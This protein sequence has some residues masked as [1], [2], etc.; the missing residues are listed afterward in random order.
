VAL[1]VSDAEMDTNNAWETIRENN[2]ASKFQ[3]KKEKVLMNCRSTNHGSKKGAQNYYIKGNNYN[4][5]N[6][7][8]CFH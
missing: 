3:P 6:R 2:L 4:R 5:P 1:E 7:K 8:H